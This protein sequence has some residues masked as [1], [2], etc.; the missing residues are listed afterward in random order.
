MKS[1]T[2]E[3]SFQVDDLQWHISTCNTHRRC[4]LLLS[5]AFCLQIVPTKGVNKRQFK[6]P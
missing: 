2:L 1:M 5:I 3:K 4:T 6:S